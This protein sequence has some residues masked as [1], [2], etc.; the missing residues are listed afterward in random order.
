MKS[1]SSCKIDSMSVF[2]IVIV[3]TIII[4]GSILTNVPAIHE[5]DAVTGQHSKKTVCIDG[6]CT[7]N[8]IVFGDCLPSEC[9]SENSIIIK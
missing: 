4:T 7:T 6:I 3:A 8:E 9:R 5:T 2:G 1:I